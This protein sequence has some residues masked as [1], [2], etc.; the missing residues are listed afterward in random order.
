[1]VWFAL[2]DIKN[3]QEIIIGVIVSLIVSLIA[4]HML[5]TTEK[6]HH[7]IKR[8]AS[9]IV[10]LFKFLWEMIKA[11]IHVAYIVVH[12]KLPIKPGI[13][14]IKTKLTKDS[15]LTILTNSITLTPGTL[16][17][18]LN[19]QNQDIYVHWIDTKYT[20]T[21]EATKEIGGRFENRLM[22]VFE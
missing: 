6:S 2:T 1:L 19:K 20:D 8:I 5:I 16:T 3:P 11:N 14:K 4:G 21:A 17:I 13:V 10:Y 9:G 18:D 12:P 15:A 22:E 7:P